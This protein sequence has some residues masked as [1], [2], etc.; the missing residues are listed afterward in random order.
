MKYRRLNTDF[1]STDPFTGL[2][3]AAFGS[4][5]PEVLQLQR[6]PDAVD[7]RSPPCLPSSCIVLIFACFAYTFA[8]IAFTFACIVLLFACIAF[9]LP[10]LHVPLPSLHLLLPALHLLC[11]H[12]ISSACI[13]IIM[14]VTGCRNLVAVVNMCLP[15]CQ[16]ADMSLMLA[17]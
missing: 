3:L 17:D 16:A 14:L 15:A 5:G 8:C 9:K 1:V 13:A 12:G 2:Y 11:L 6:E 10:A 7:V 4:H